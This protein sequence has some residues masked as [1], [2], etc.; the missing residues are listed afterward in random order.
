MQMLTLPFHTTAQVRAR[1]K[2]TIDRRRLCNAH[3]SPHWPYAARAPTPL[4]T[5]WKHLSL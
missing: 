3:V 1:R 4:F 5:L 2:L